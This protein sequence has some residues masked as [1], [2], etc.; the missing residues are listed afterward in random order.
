MAKGVLR[1]LTC[2]S[3]DDGKSTLIGRLL[4]DG[5]L[6][7]DDQ[8]EAI[9]SENQSGE[10]LD[11]SLLLDGLEA[12]RE[13]GITIDVAYRYFSTQHRRFIV[14]DTPGHEQYTRNM[15]TG[16]S[17]ADLAI[18]L[19]DARNGIL[20]QTLRH[21]YIAS[22]FGIRHVV[23]AV[24][25]MDLIEYS[26][27]TFR[28]IA[29]AFS[30][31]VKDHRFSSLISI[32][33]SALKGDNVYNKC[34]ATAW[35]NGPTLLE[36]LEN[37]E[38]VSELEKQP[39]RMFV[40]RVNRPNPDFRGYSGT[41]STG[42][43]SV[44]DK[45]VIA[46][47][48]RISR[49][50]SIVTADGYLQEAVAGDA[51]TILLEDE[52]DIARGD[53]LGCI[54][55][56]P[57]LSDQFRVKLLWMDTE[58]MLPGRTYEVKIGSQ[59]TN[60]KV[61]DLRHA[62]AVDTMEH[63]AARALHLNEIGE[64]NIT[65]EKE[66]SFDPF[67][68]NKQMGSF[69]LIDRYSK[70]T[71][72]AGVIE[73]GLRRAQ[74]IIHQTFDV[75][76]IARSRLKNQKPAALWFTGLSG[77]GKSTIANQIEKELHKLGFHTYILDGDNIRSGLNGDLGF[78]DADRVE[79]IRRISEVAKLFVDAGII[80]LTAFISPFRSEREMARSLLN[81]QEFIEIFIDTPLEV[82]ESR[83]PKGLYAKARTGAIT[84]FTG[85]DSDYEPPK[86]P[87]IHLKTAGLKPEE[88]ANIVLRYLNENEII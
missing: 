75:D 29:K 52:I 69:I 31:L 81:S 41:I 15:A 21:A 82:C 38:V 43:I 83:D 53:V 68:Q 11:F 62:I 46:P 88:A 51:I 42:R 66:I 56:P 63:V 19:V 23:L 13:Q 8:L 86:S 5:E 58:P 34:A 79:N 25:K 72:A 73:F 44:G 71:V 76:K 67:E 35:Y 84:N 45:I 20:R 30:D 27:T 55:M 65:F 39:F 85:I 87:E 7:L 77:S 40:Q 37:I 47:S 3:V 12:E 22:L 59:M 78:T 17:T 14:A 28:Q 70:H 50:A 74:N 48:E 60:A 54:T 10:D 36:H 32:P 80:V 16:A 24:N 64:C 26:E 9:I 6:I 2:G 1:F 18:I 49:I 61:T 4:Y 57:E 33:L